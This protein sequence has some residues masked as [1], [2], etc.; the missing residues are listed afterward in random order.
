MFLD[1]SVGSNNICM[2]AFLNRQIFVQNKKLNKFGKYFLPVIQ[3][4]IRVAE[5]SVRCIGVKNEGNL[6]CYD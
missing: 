5:I 4:K 6:G 3:Y 2:H 1:S